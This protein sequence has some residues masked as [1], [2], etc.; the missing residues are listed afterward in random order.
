MPISRI[1]GAGLDTGSSGVAPSN[2]STGA[3]SWDGSGNVTVSGRQLIT[4]QPAFGFY[5]S[6]GRS[7][8]GT[9]TNYSL[10]LGNGLNVGSCFD[11]V[12]GI[13][14]APVAGKYC[15]AFAF[16]KNVANIGRTIMQFRIN[17]VAGYEALETYGAYQDVGGAIVL[18]LSAN[19]N[20][21]LTYGQVDGAWDHTAGFSGYLI[22]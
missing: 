8:T 1:P 4:A 5:V 12:T 6:A 9:F 20:V 11:L 19:D 21:R 13:F 10:T 18:Q 2:L 14:T 15:F 3:P 7:S 17:D 22:G 16:K